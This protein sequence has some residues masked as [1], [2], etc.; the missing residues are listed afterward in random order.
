MNS[1]IPFRQEEKEWRHLRRYHDQSADTL[2]ELDQLILDSMNKPNNESIKIKAWEAFGKFTRG[3]ADLIENGLS[4]NVDYTSGYAIYNYGCWDCTMA[5]II[6]QFKKK[7]YQADK[8]KGQSANPKSFIESL[9]SWQ[10]LSPIGFAFDIVNDPVS[11]ITKKEIQMFLHEDYGEMGEY[12]K[13]ATILQY[14]LRFGDKVGIAVCVKGHPSFGMKD[15]SHWVYIDPNS[16]NELV[17]MFD[18]STKVSNNNESTNFT[19]TKVYEICAYSTPENIQNI[20]D[21]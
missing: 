10:I 5:M 12:V 19:Y 21:S 4:K 9:R 7:V 1:F 16:T 3:L 15:K 2:Q 17:L 18:P 6:S 20:F 14:A 11:I 8:R 13:S